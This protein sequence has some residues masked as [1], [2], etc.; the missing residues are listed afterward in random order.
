MSNIISDAV[1]KLSAIT[2]LT[3]TDWEAFDAVLNRL[4]D[5]NV[6]DEQYEETILS[7]LILSGDFYHHGAIL[8]DIVRHFLACGYDVSAN[9][10]RNGGLALR[11]L[12]WS[13]YDQHILKAAKVLL[14]AGAPVI[15]R[16]QDDDPGEEPEGLLGVINWKI[17]GAWMADKDFAFANILE[18]YY[19]MAETNL[20]GKEPNSID[21]YFACI[22]RSLT[23]V[24]A[25]KIGGDP[26]LRAEGDISVYSEPLIIWFEDKPLVVSCY[27]DF[28]V[29]PVYANEKKDHLADVT[30]VFSSLVGATLQEVQYIGTTICYF[31]FSNGKRLFFASRDIGDGK[32]IGTFDIRSDSGKVNIEQL[33]IRSF[34]AIKGCSF[35]STVTEYREDAIALFCD[36]AAY[37]LYLRPGAEDRPHLDLCPCSRALLAEYTR[38]YPLL[39][40]VKTTGLY[41][42]NDLFAVRLDFP[43]GYLYMAATEHYNI[44][45]QLSDKLYD[46]LEHSF[47]P[48]KGG[49]HMEFLRRKDGDQL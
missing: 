46:P 12:C 7:E 35:S 1:C 34:C 14:N 39:H 23:S 43:E 21:S 45:I 42:Q 31:E 20:A 6:Y 47:L 37:L 49:K 22:G 33:R 36:D 17:S 9:E 13:S 3:P 11:A 40:P 15:Y 10:G 24:S 18:A 44:E 48:Y 30:A 27:T 26:A 2:D 19:A 16:S 5:I 25:I 41:K 8:T 4:E 32:R 38:Q 28:V 29:N